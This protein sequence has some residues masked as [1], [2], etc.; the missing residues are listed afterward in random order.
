M[1]SWFTIW[2]ERQL[3]PYRPYNLTKL[4]KNKNCDLLHSC[5]NYKPNHGIQG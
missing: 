1:V 2:K 4:K 3:F 5:D